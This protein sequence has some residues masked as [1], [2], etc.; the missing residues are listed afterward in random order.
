MGW[1]QPFVVARLQVCAELQEHAQCVRL[2]PYCRD[3]GWRPLAGV[4]VD[5]CLPQ[6]EQRVDVPRKCGGEST[7]HPALR[8]GG[9]G[10]VAL[11][12]AGRR[13]GSRTHPRPGPA[14]PSHAQTPPPTGP[15]GPL[16]TS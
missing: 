2:A 14:A 3:V 5:P 13:P 15:R 6:L 9:R 7:Q 12:A 1:S 8:G 16:L 11:S 4:K 10:R